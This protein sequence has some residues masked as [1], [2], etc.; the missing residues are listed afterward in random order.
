MLGCAR[1]SVGRV[2]G[3]G[4]TRRGRRGTGRTRRGGAEPGE[5]G[6]RMRRASRKLRP[7]RR[8]SRKTKPSTKGTPQSEAG[9]NGRDPEP[10]EH[11]SQAAK[12]T[13]TLRRSR[14]ARPNA[15]GEP[16]SGV[17]PPRGNRKARPNAAG[18]PQSG[19]ETHDPRVFGHALRFSWTAWT[20]FAAP[21]DCSDTFCGSAQPLAGALR[22]AP[23]AWARLAAHAATP[24][25]TSLPQPNDRRA[26]PP[27]AKGADRA[28]AYCRLSTFS[29]SPT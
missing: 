28:H 19:A 20:R 21:V 9:R 3:R 18:E 13:R 2:A 5:H 27:T 15:A 12:R 10:S 14:K 6:A 11:R 4:R 29:T 7:A 17:E 22:L 1:R 26:I 16:Q 8:A 24:G 25:T 23:T